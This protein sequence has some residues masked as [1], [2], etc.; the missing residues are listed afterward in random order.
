M[1]RL[2]SKGK[3]GRSKGKAKL[4]KRVKIGVVGLV[5]AMS[6]TGVYSFLVAPNNGSQPGNPI[7]YF[8]STE[9]Q[10]AFIYPVHYNNWTQDYR[11][12]YPNYTQQ[13]YLTIYGNLPK[14]QKNLE[15]VAYGVYNHILYDLQRIPANYYQQPEFYPSWNVIRAEQ[16][17]NLYMNNW[18]L[19]K[20]S[21]WTPFGFTSYPDIQQVSASPGSTVTFYFWLLPSWF[22]VAYQG[23][24]L[25]PT[26]QPNIYGIGKILTTQNPTYADEFLSVHIDNQNSP[27]LAQAIQQNGINGQEGIPAG[28]IFETLVPVFPAFPSSWVVPITVTVS[29]ASDATPGTYAW[30]MNT[31]NPSSAIYQTMF[32]QYGQLYVNSGSTF[33]QSFQPLFEGIVQVT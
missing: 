10:G 26:F 25:S 19:N 31:S 1:K 18:P 30:T 33:I 11:P 13:Q 32:A 24:I 4:S 20:S 22:V 6:I 29:I 21:T 3:N 16:Q 28:S 7:F 12:L 5:I 27:L 23:M 14:E 15:V 9:D 17:L 2:T 8:G